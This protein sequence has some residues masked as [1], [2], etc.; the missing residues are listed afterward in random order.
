MRG[1]GDGGRPV[2]ECGGGLGLGDAFVARAG[3]RSSLMESIVVV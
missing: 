2:P 3:I 1:I